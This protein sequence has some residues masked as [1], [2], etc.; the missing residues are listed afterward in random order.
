MG[1]ETWRMEQDYK[2][3]L[4]RDLAERREA[5]VAK[6]YE[7]EVELN[8]DLRNLVREQQQIRAQAAASAQAE[9]AEL[10]TQIQALQEQQGQFR[11]QFSPNKT[12]RPGDLNGAD[13]AE[14]QR[15]SKQLEGLKDRQMKLNTNPVAESSEASSRVSELQAQID[16]VREKQGILLDKKDGTGF[17]NAGEAEAQAEPPSPEV[18][19][20]K[21]QYD[22]ANNAYEAKL[23]EE[24]AKQ[25]EVDRLNG[26]IDPT[27]ADKKNFETLKQQL[28]RT[29]QAAKDAKAAQDAARTKLTEAKQKLTQAQQEA[30]GLKD[31]IAQQEDKVK[32]L[33]DKV[34]DLASTASDA[35]K[36]LQE[37]QQK[38]AD[39]VQKRQDAMNSIN[40]PG[41][42]QSAPTTGPGSGHP[43]IDPRTGQV[44]PRDKNYDPLAGSVDK[45]KPDWA[46]WV[47]EKL[48]NGGEVIGEKLKQGFGVQSPDEIAQIMAEAKAALE[49]KFQALQDKMAA[50]GK[51]TDDLGLNVER[52]SDY[53]ERV[54][55]EG[56]KGLKAQLDNCITSH[57]YYTGKGESGTSPDQ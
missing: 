39:A 24:A 52:G 33:E 17:R 8:S 49:A 26:Q 43:M 38:K 57:T 11:K 14:Y 15:M 28:E 30:G 3:N 31:K 44:I 13:L 35:A 45:W 46:Y 12:F 40:E 1:L 55:Q 6:M 50:Y 4:A 18:Q 54:A 10:D 20:Q 9:L 36:K 56:A 21:Q 7:E 42:G 51:A 47:E 48:R 34:N 23:K 37:A 5:K 22:A 53:W 16:A 41:D 29:E 32:Q 27:Y 19:A 25:A 2:K